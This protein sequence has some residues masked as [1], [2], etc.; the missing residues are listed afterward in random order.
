MRPSSLQLEAARVHHG[1]TE[2]HRQLARQLEEAQ[3][4]RQELDCAIRPTEHMQHSE[5]QNRELDD[6][7][8]TV[9]LINGQLLRLEGQ[10]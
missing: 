3:S 8:F 4:I 5:V 1:S 2:L 7:R 6:L 9:S 10:S